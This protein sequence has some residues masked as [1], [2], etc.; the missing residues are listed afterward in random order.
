MATNRFPDEILVN[1]F[2]HSLFDEDLECPTDVPFWSE[3]RIEAFVYLCSWQGVCRIA[4]IRYISYPS[5]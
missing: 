2:S 5:R 1:I 3:A 4:F